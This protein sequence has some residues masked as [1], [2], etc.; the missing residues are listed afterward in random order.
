AGGSYAPQAGMITPHNFNF[1]QSISFVSAVTI[2]GA[3]SSAGPL[4]GAVVVGSSPESSSSSEEYRSLFFGAFSS[5]VSWAAPDGAAG[6]SARWRRRGAQP[7]STPRQGGSAA[8]G[9]ARRVSRADASAMTF[10]GVRAVQG[11]SF[12]VAPAAVTALIGPNG[13]GK[14][15][16]INMLSGYYQ[17]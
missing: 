15:T 17:P 13:A 9:Q 10:G 12:Q 5:V 8:T 4:S 2:G 16:V 1:M 3:G 14:S 7:R 11:V 6:L